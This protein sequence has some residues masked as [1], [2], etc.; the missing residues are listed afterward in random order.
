MNPAEL[1]E[2]RQAARE[3]IGI[4]VPACIRKCDTIREGIELSASRLHKLNSKAHEVVGW[5]LLLPVHSEKTHAF[6]PVAG[7]AKEGIIISTADDEIG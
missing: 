2:Q 4:K 6:T 5:G 7:E 3:G 1:L